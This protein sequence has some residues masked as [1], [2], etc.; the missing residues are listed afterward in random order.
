M[1]LASSSEVGREKLTHSGISLALR[2]AHITTP[3]NAFMNHR[4]HVIDLMTSNYNVE[5]MP[6]KPMPTKHRVSSSIFCFL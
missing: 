4:F 2:P 6:T 3:L 1:T 5:A